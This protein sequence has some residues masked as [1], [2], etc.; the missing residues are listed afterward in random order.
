MKICWRD[1]PFVLCL[2]MIFCFVIFFYIF[3]SLSYS[4][5]EIFLHLIPFASKF[6]STHCCSGILAVFKLG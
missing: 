6:I 5:V 2:R 3:Q 1:Q 4:V